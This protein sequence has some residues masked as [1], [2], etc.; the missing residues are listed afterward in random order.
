MVVGVDLHEYRYHVTVSDA[1][2]ELFSRV[3]AG[4]IGGTS[5]VLKRYEGGG[6]QVACEAGYFGF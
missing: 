5:S 3:M 1:D 2:L 4:R 6:I